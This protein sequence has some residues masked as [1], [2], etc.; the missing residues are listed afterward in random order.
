MSEF[1]PPP[2]PGNP[3]WAQAGPYGH[4]SMPPPPTRSLKGLATAVT[5][6]FAVAAVGDLVAAAAR[7][8]RAGL[9]DDFLDNPTSVQFQELLDADDAVAASTVFYALAALA[10]VIVL[11]IWQ[12]RHA[13]NAEV[14]GVRGGLGPGWAIGGWFIPVANF[15]LPGMQMFQSSKGS[16]VDARRAGRAPK[17][18]GLIIAWAILFA[19]GSVLLFSSPAGTTTD[20]DGNRVF[21]S[22]QDVEDAASSDR[23]AAAGFVVLM[24]AAGLGIAMVRTLTKKQTA[25]YAQV[26]T[27]APPPPGGVQP[28]Y[29]VAPP[30]ASPPGA[31]PDYG[32]TLPPTTPPPPPPAPPSAPPE[33]PPPPGSFEAPS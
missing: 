20:E 9:L 4:T 25:A 16:D 6:L 2:P 31:A 7:N 33:P 17:G 22:V 8:S 30:A 3:Q 23:R 27:A 29:G 11:I 12:W 14:L 32:I 26:V 13:K 1:L 10:L 19:L 24:V 18:V 5:V 28:P 21:D 15:V